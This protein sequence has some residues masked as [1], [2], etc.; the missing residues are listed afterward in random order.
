M[1]ITFICFKDLIRGKNTLE[2]KL[3]GYPDTCDLKFGINMLK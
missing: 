3:T 2:I 1:F